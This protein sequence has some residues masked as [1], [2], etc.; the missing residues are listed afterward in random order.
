VFDAIGAMVTQGRDDRLSLLQ[1]GY[2][3]GPVSEL[4]G[5]GREQL[6]DPWKVPVAARDET[7]LHELFTQLR[8]GVGLEPPEPTLDAALH[9]PL[10][11]RPRFD[12][13]YEPSA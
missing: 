12:L 10:S 11:R 13:E 3:L 4:T 8:A 7:L 2:N 6:R 5:R 9:K 1:L